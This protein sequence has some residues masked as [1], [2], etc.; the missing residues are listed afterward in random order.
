MM[1]FGQQTCILSGDFTLMPDLNLKRR[2]NVLTSAGSFPKPAV[3]TPA[4]PCLELLIHH[5]RMMEV[6]GAKIKKPFQYSEPHQVRRTAE[7][8]IKVRPRKQN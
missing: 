6:V 2:G 4:I 7:E 3:I 5:I 1:S 8:R